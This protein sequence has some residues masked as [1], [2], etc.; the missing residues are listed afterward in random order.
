MIWSDRKNY[1]IK[2]I[3]DGLLGATL[4]QTKHYIWPATMS[5]D[6][7]RDAE[8]FIALHIAD[9]RDGGL[10]EALPADGWTLKSGWHLDGTGNKLNKVWSKNI[11]AGETITFTSTK[12]QM[13]FAILIKEGNYNV[14]FIKVV[15]KTYIV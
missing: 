3:S 2:S 5:I 13:T 6:S 1:Q 4:F 7:N 8:I 14:C 12:N 9:D 10:M 11:K 15:T